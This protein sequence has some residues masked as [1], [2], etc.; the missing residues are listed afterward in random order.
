[1]GYCSFVV[2][3]KYEALENGNQPTWSRKKK[4]HAQDMVEGRGMATTMAERRE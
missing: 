4:V 3:F 1:M 2:N